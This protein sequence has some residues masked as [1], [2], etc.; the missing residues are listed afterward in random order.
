VSQ[1]SESLIPVPAQPADGNPSKQKENFPIRWPS[2]CGKDYDVQSEERS[3]SAI[4][5]L[6]IIEAVHQLD[7]NYER[8]SG[9]VHIAQGPSTQPAGTIEM[10]MAY[11]VSRKVDITSV[12]YAWS[13]S[14]ITIGDPSF[15]DGFDGIRKGRACLGMSIVIYVAP[16][17]SLENLNVKST[18]MGMQVHSGVNFAV[19]N[20]TSV[21]LTTGTLDSVSFPSRSTH[22]ETISGSIS[23]KYALYDSLTV[24]TK[25]GSVNINIEPKEMA[26]GGSEIAQFKATSQSGSMRVDFERKNIPDR[27]YK[28][29]IE[30]TVGSVDGTFI[31]G[32]SSTYST[33]AGSVNADILPF[34]AGDY[35]SLLSTLTTDGQTNIKLRSP[36]K[37]KGKPLSK[38]VSTH[39]SIS[40]LL[41]LEY[42]Q[43]WE[44]RVQ[45][46]TVSGLLHLQGK[47]LELINQEE[48]EGMNRVEARK[49]NDA[50]GM[51]VFSTTSGGC[52]IKVGKLDAA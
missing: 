31:H 17:T 30:T 8:V 48:K 42:P 32:S 11:A 34:K 27:D 16:G 43:E 36:Y 12:K 52:E 33:I 1:K 10:K 9:W 37:N 40:G 38:L 28:L 22:L 47:D 19:T 29:E 4:P 44:G 18:H 41:D 20:R 2:R 23:G 49:G 24:A 3:F 51:M 5:N 21:S 13:A 26:N 50:G 39:K 6:D 46:E 14:G 45:G 35:A 25:S 15:P 7:G